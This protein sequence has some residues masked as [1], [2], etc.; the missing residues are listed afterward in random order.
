MTRFVAAFGLVLIL[1]SCS[2]IAVPPDKRDFIGKWEG[3]GVTLVLTAD[4][5]V[6]YVNVGGVG[7]KEINA[8][9]QSFSADGFEVGAMGITTTFRVDKPPFEADGV[10][11]MI[12]DGVTLTRVPGSW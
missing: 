2:G 3:P 10:W 7:K 8:P 4:G 11:Q 9:L 12:V 1:V 6:H 5:G